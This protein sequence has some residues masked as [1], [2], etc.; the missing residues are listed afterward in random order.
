[1]NKKKDPE[2][3]EDLYNHYAAYNP[4]DHR[5]RVDVGWVVRD[6]T[7]FSNLVKNR[8]L[9]KNMGKDKEPLNLINE[10]LQVLSLIHI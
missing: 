7:L 1:M 4:S 10:A 2:N 9:T 8:G 5:I 3:D 6:D